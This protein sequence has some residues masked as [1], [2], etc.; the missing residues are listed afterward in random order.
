MTYP[1]NDPPTHGKQAGV[2][3]GALPAF[4]AGVSGLGGGG[5]G[6][7]RIAMKGANCRKG[8]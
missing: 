2:K 8:A 5:D 7:F 3:A 6:L 4:K 1:A